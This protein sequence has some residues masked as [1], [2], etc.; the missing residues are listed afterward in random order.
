MALAENIAKSGRLNTTLG[1]IL[2]VLVAFVVSGLGAEFAVRYTIAD[3]I[4]LFPRNHSAVQYGDFTLRRMQPNL[5]FWHQSIDG[6]WRF[7]TNNA[8]FR[9][10]KPYNYK[11]ANGELRVL[12]LGDSHTEG[13]EVQQ[14]ETFS[15]RFETL[16]AGQGWNSSVKHWRL[17]L[18][19]SGGAR[20][21]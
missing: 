20:I 18:R 10:D 2:V 17:R 6:K 19:H 1:S 14:D 13:F 8:G 11:K 16:L 9:D 5:V 21:F 7:K 12:V 15:K 3:R 4:V